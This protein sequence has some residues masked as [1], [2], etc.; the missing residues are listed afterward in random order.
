MQ[1]HPQPA[2]VL[3]TFNQLP[4]Q[5]IAHFPSNEVTQPPPFRFQERSVPMDW[6]ALQ[7]INVSKIIKETGIASLEVKFSFNPRVS[8]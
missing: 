5:K 7:R 2:F 3:P 1:K 6:R 8:Y 4:A